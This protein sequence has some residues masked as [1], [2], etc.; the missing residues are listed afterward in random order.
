MS[1]FNNDLA[2]RAATHFEF[3]HCFLLGPRKRQF[4]YVRSTV[5]P[6]LSNMRRIERQASK[7]VATNSANNTAKDDP[8]V[9]RIIDSSKSVEDEVRDLLGLSGHTVA[10]ASLRGGKQ[11]QDS[12]RDVLRK[13]RRSR[14]ASDEQRRSSR[15][16]QSDR[17]SRRRLVKGLSSDRLNDVTTAESKS[18]EAPSV[19]GDEVA[20]THGPRR[21]S[22][23]RRG[24]RRNLGVSKNEV[25]IYASNAEGLSQADGDPSHVTATEA[26]N[27][28]MEL[29]LPNQGGGLSSTKKIETLKSQSFRRRPSARKLVADKTARRRSSLK[30]EASRRSLHSDNNNSEGTPVSN[31]ATRRRSSLKKEGSRRSLHSDNDTNEG[32]DLMVDTTP[33]GQKVQQKGAISPAEINS[34]DV[35][36]GSAISTS[37]GRRPSLMGLSSKQPSSSSIVFQIAE[38]IDPKEKEKMRS[39]TRS[40]LLKPCPKDTRRQSEVSQ[41]TKPVIS[42]RAGDTSADKKK[43][44]QSRKR[45]KSRRSRRGGDSSSDINDNNSSISSISIGS[46]ASSTQGSVDGGYPFLDVTEDVDPVAQDPPVAQ[47]DLP[48]K[49]IELKRR[50]SSLKRPALLAMSRGGSGREL[51]Q[52]AANACSNKVEEI[53]FEQLNASSIPSL[54]DMQQNLSSDGESLEFAHSS[55]G[56]FKKTTGA[57]DVNS[58]RTSEMDIDRTSADFDRIPK[59]PI[60]VVSDR[61]SRSHQAVDHENTKTPYGVHETSNVESIEETKPRHSEPQRGH[62]SLPLTPTT[63]SQPFDRW[64][65]ETTPI[66]HV[67]T[68]LITQLAEEETRQVVGILYD[69]PTANDSAP[70]KSPANRWTADYTASSGIS[71]LA[72]GG[73]RFPSFKFSRRHS[74]YRL[75]TENSPV[76]PQQQPALLKQRRSLGHVGPADQLRNLFSDGELKKLDETGYF[77]FVSYQKPSKIHGIGDERTEA[78]AV[79]PDSAKVESPETVGRTKY[80]QAPSH[81][82]LI[83]RKATIQ[84]SIAAHRKSIEELEKQLAS[85]DQQLESTQ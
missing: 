26:A 33:R 4:C 48:R 30:K 70:I 63:P 78:G 69:S 41:K 38:P 9:G 57:D 34:V 35:D 51:L 85:L 75:S 58:A 67:S 72:V 22:N 20:C 11:R 24:S 27:S 3:A 68:P 52:T 47:G 50:R 18:A 37:I 16:L 25:A 65:A 56:D 59:S 64:E 54:L 40:L 8:L 17:T 46:L 28:N 1:I 42:K 71:K 6:L 74:E 45:E 29:R 23:T 76:R 66:S 55:K 62:T 83:Q 31:K 7:E 44:R 2:Q 5:L 43:K 80:L 12:A 53:R 60:R 14:G 73:L 10:S 19:D 32:K 84:D 79:S 61:S 13:S 39:S 81:Q 15:M 36:G 77:N 49:S 21:A 82:D